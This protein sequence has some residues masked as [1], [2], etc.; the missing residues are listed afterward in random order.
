ML[1][2][3]I[4]SENG[5]ERRMPLKEL[6]D[7]IRN[8]ARQKYNAAYA[9]E[10]LSPAYDSDVWEL[11]NQIRVTKFD[12][13]YE[14]KA[15]LLCVNGDKIQVSQFIEDLKAI[16][17]LRVGTCD[18]VTLRGMIRYSIRCF[19]ESGGYQK[20]VALPDPPALSM[21]GYFMDFLMVLPYVSPE[22][23]SEA[24]KKLAAVRA[25]MAEFKRG[26][27]R[28]CT[29]NEFKSYFKLDD[30]IN[31]FFEEYENTSLGSY[32]M[33][34]IIFWKVTT[35]LPMRVTEFC[36]TPYECLRQDKDLY[37]L[38]VRRSHLKGSSSFYPKIHYYRIDKDYDEYEYEIPKAL[39]D[40]IYKFQTA[41][42]DYAHPYGLLFSTEYTLSCNVGHSIKATSEKTFG[43]D[44]MGILIKDFYSIVLV[45]KLGM[46]LVDEKMLE[47]RYLDTIDGSYEMADDEI[48]M[49]QAK[50]TRHL[51]M[52]NLIM[53]GCNPMMIREFAGHAD[54]VTSAHYY[55]NVSKTVRCA[56]K[57]L[58]DKVK[59]QR[60]S[61]K[62]V[63]TVS[64]VN[65]LSLL[66]DTSKQ[67]V[68]VDHGR[69]YSP[70]FLEGSIHDCGNV[71]GKCD[72]CQ[73]FIASKENA[74]IHNEESFVDKE[75][76][77]LMKLLKNEK[78]ESKMLEFQVKAQ[79][80]ESDMVNLS[81]YY[82]QEFM[83][84]D[85][86]GEKEKV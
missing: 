39:Y 24:K 3:S 44:Q 40:M 42:K 17:A 62:N 76:E 85:R 26:Q 71:D 14:R 50:H 29:L 15:V 60:H 5:L 64:E 77:Y 16:T 59:N 83:K 80:L 27:R 8:L 19:I 21:I 45:G 74:G 2:I 18:A 10:I 11:D 37:Y 57:I 73:Y 38:T 34:F 23:L 70:A 25:K 6:T 41:T 22:Y 72:A 52:I 47:T 75:L 46:S 81:T 63:K 78:I 86:D 36:V 33:P 79:Q 7:D 49:L 69:C 55:G 53:R 56:T 43:T 67:S 82:W 12:F 61:N 54:E 20:A 66:I 35:I 68:A 31:R 48:M 65:P 28:A 51:A 9:Q 13:T 4:S 1:Q 58:Y 30:V 32:F 84:G